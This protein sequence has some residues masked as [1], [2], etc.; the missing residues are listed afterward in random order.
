[1]WNSP[2]ISVFRGIQTNINAFEEKQAKAGAED[3]QMK[4]IGRD[5][6]M[7]TIDMSQVADVLSRQERGMDAVRQSMADLNAAH[8]QQ[9]EGRRL[10]TQ[11]LLERLAVGQAGAENRARIAE[12]VSRRR[13]DMLT[14]DRDKVMATAA[15][16][17]GAGAGGGGGGVVNNNVD[18]RQVDS[19]THYH[20]TVVDQNTHNQMV[21]L[22]QKNIPQF[23][24]YMQQNNMNQECPA[25]HSLVS[26]DKNG[27]ATYLGRT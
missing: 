1:M 16:A 9:E 17:A 3:A 11:S 22:I 12:E 4:Q 2:E 7:N 24:A 13:I 27:V 15:A 5:Q 19:S 26:S 21:S 8:A 25:G 18:N 10:E 23:G 6:G 20:Q 14:E